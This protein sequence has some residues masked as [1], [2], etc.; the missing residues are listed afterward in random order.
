MAAGLFAQ[1]GNSL[2]LFIPYE[3]PHC[4]TTRKISEYGGNIFDGAVCP[5]CGKDPIPQSVGESNNNNY[6][7][8][9]Q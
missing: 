6:A 4:K 2:G 3:C 1:M 9:Y 5:K 8:Y 7:Q